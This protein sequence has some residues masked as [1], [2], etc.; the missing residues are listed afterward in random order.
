LIPAF[1]ETVEQI[2]RNNK[3]VLGLALAALLAAAPASAQT[4]QF[5]PGGVRILPPGYD[6][7]YRYRDERFRERGISER[8]AIRI[9]RRHGLDEVRNVQTRR[10]S[11]RVVGFDRRD[12]RLTVVVDRRDGDVLS[13]RRRFS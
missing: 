5:G 9:A 6:E 7:P 8:Q 12:N 3:A 4:I 1:Q 13:V 2:M 11:I 10:D